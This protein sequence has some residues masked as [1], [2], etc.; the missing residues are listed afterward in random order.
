[1]RYIL[2]LALPF[3]IFASSQLC[4]TCHPI[5]Y[6]EYKESMHY[7]STLQRDPL[8]K[9][10]WQ[11]HPLKKS[12]SYKCAKCHDPNLSNK[13]E[14]GVDCISCHKI[15]DIKEHS[16]ANENIYE[17]KEKLFYSKDTKQKNKIIHYHK[18]SSFLGLFTKTIGSPYHDIDY[19]NKNFYTAKVC[20]GCHSHLKNKNKLTICQT[21]I[22]GASSEK[23]NCISCHMPKVQGSATT[24]KNTKKHAYHGFLGVYNNPKALA[25]YI[26]LKAS[27]TDNI[28]KIT[29]YNN[30]PHPLLTQPL[31]LAEIKIILKNKK[32]QKI[33][34]K[35]SISFEKIF[36]KK[37]KRVMPP[38]ATQIKKDTMLQAN[39]KRVIELKVPTKKNLQSIISFGYYRVDPTIAKKLQLNN[40][41]L[42]EFIELKSKELP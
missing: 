33:I 22:Q 36:T 2:L 42:K 37:N 26:D 38:L 34:Y 21:P 18:E 14:K 23:N 24:I 8:H 35:K 15:K 6:N 40:K 31:R 17:K 4:K 3:T 10:I 7:K 32:S 41:D 30:A 39:E 16:I 27:I 20:M 9:A 13:L 12:N 11:K 1:M 28:L 29:I 19:R 5:I 25:K